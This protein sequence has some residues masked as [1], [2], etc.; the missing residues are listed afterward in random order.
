MARTRPSYDWSR[1]APGEGPP[2]HDP[3]TLRAE[4]R[5][6]E[7]ERWALEDAI[8]RAIARQAPRSRAPT[9]ASVLNSPWLP[10]LGTVCFLMLLAYL[11]THVH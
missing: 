10:G 8:A 11:Q 6:I 5:A 2:V 3:E 7:I 4:Q 9:Y 1:L